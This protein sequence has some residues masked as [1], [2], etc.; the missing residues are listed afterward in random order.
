MSDKSKLSNASEV[1]PILAKLRRKQPEEYLFI[2]WFMINFVA[3]AIPLLL[4]CCMVAVVKSFTAF[5]EV[6]EP[7]D[8]YLIGFGLVA[9][10][11]IELF[12]KGPNA[13]GLA[14][15]GMFGLLA[16]VTTLIAP[17]LA[18]L[19]RTGTW[20]AWAFAVGYFLIVELALAFNFTQGK[21]PEPAPKDVSDQLPPGSSNVKR[22]SESN[23]R[24]PS[25]LGWP[26]SPSS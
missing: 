6:V 19:A 16:G 21:K 22:P 2:Q 8:I 12:G 17:I 14:M 9:A 18:P 25:G 1:E 20:Q 7:R 5:S 15:L 24:T 3:L 23:Y 4:A 26:S 10:R 11:I 13:P